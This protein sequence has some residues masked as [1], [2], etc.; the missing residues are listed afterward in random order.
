MPLIPGPASAAPVLSPCRRKW[1]LKQ[2]L[3]VLCSASAACPCHGVLHLLFPWFFQ[4]HMSEPSQPH[5]PTAGGP[6]P[7]TP[8]DTPPMHSGSSSPTYL[9]DSPLPTATAPTSLPA[10][11]ESASTELVKPRPFVV[12][13]VV[14]VTLPPRVES[15]RKWR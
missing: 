4:V 11:V 6:V 10:A 2:G 5:S 7:E 3:K 1:S 9:Q 15:A 12:P 14:K 8:P 13:A